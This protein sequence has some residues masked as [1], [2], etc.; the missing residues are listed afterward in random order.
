MSV[1]AM[2]LTVFLVLFQLLAVSGSFVD[3]KIRAFIFGIYKHVKWSKNLLGIQMSFWLSLA[4]LTKILSL[5]VRL[6]RINQL[7]FGF[8]ILNRQLKI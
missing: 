7:K 5:P 3:Q 8:Q 6:A 4:I 1:I 2:R